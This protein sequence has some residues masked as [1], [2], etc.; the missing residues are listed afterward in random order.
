[1]IPP[2][3]D[4]EAAETL[5]RGLSALNIPLAAGDQMSLLA[6]LSLMQKWNRVYN[7]TAITNLREMLVRHLLDSLAIAPHVGGHRVLDVG[8]GPGLPGLPLA[9]ALPHVQFTLLDSVAKKTRFV[10]QVISEL[11]LNNVTVET[12]RVERY[13]PPALFDVV[14]SRAFSGLAEFV[15]AAGAHCLPDGRL[16]AMKGRYPV[17]EL[18]ALPPAYHLEKAVRLSVPGLNEERHALFL[19]REARPD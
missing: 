13:H 19:R 12:A 9:I 7:L 5:A 14:I 6:F 4:I 16:L 8:T 1:M 11:G 3:A 15:T 10:I 18:E 2:P 17:D